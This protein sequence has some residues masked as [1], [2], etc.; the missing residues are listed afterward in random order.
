MS[1]VPPLSV[2]APLASLLRLPIK[3]Y[4]YTLSAVMGRRCRFLPTCSEY[5]DEAIGRH[6]AVQGS[7]LAAKRIC[8][9]HPWG[10][11]GFDPVPEAL[12]STPGWTRP[13]RYRGG[14]ATGPDRT[15]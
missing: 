11:S 5:A 15:A 2:H 14:P 4:R 10:G 6:G 3:L 1:P 9:C 12:P 7:W 13:W 8:R